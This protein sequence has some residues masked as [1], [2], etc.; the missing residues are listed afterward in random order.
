MY[1]KVKISTLMDSIT[2][3]KDKKSW[4][5]AVKITLEI[6]GNEVDLAVSVSPYIQ[7]DTLKGHDIPHSRMYLR[8]A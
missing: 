2:T 6:E 1:E 4:F 8:D 7:V 3:F 5:P